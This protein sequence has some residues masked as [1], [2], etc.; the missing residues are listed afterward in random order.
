[1]IRNVRPEMLAIAELQTS[2]RR[3]PWNMTM[4][5]CWFDCA[6]LGEV[7]QRIAASMRSLAGKGAPLASEIPS[8][9]DSLSRDADV[10]DHAALAL[11]RSGKEEPDHDRILAILR[12]TTD[13]RH[14]DRLALDL[15]AAPPPTTSADALEELTEDLHRM[16]NLALL[17]ISEAREALDSS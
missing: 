7:E 10:I 13:S 2:K 12:M 4:M 17:H 6:L 11:V 9:T 14:I 8:A 15:A 16:A 5:I 3:S 1:M